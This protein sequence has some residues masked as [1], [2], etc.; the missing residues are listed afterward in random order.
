MNH[1]TDE[2]LNEYLDNE[3]ADRALV[4]QHLSTCADCAAR[5]VA[6]QAL[7]A[8]LDSLTEET[9]TRP[10][11]SRLA[12]PSN[13]PA[14]LPRSLRLAVTL[15]AALAVIAI[16][17]AMPFAMEFVSP[18]LVTV[19]MPSLTEIVFQ[20]QSQWFAWLDLLSQFQLPTLPEIP[21]VEIS[22]LYIALTLA[23]MSILWLI[24]NGLLLRNH[25][26]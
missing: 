3:L 12:L 14:A 18:Y 13:L 7:F 2:L 24:G 1:L 21:V 19:Q 5:L 20:A 6:F 26:K 10:I 23:G 8:E 16:I 22:S 11:A 9:L 17:I 15:Q 4:E 25:I